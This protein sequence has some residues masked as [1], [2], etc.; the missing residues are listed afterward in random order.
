MGH[1]VQPGRD[2]QM[3]T[4]NKIRHL[5]VGK[6][7]SWRALLLHWKYLPF[8][9]SMVPSQH[10]TILTQR[11]L[12][13]RAMDEMRH[14]YEAA[15]TPLGAEI[16]WFSSYRDLIAYPE[17]SERM[18][19]I[20]DLD[21]LDSPVDQA[22]EQIRTSFAGSDLIAL[23][24]LDSAQLALQCIRSGFTDF[25]LKPTSPE[26]LAWSARRCLQRHEFFDRIDPSTDILR[27]VTQ[28]SS[29][30]S[31]NLVRL[32]T[33]EHLVLLAQCKGAAWLRLERRGE[34]PPRALAIFPKQLSE[35][36]VL[37][38]LPAGALTTTPKTRVYRSGRSLIRKVLVP[39]SN[40][41]ESLLFLWGVPQR[42]SASTLAQAELLVEYAETNIANLQKFQE[43]RHQT[44]IDDLT[45]L[46]NSR[47]L[48]FALS[49][50]MLKCKGPNDH[51]SVLF[52]D[53]DHF[54]AV[55]DRFNH[56]IGS[57][58]LVAIG[59]TIKNTVRQID[60]VFRYGGDEFVVILH[61]TSLEGALEIGERI[62]KSVER[63]IF[64]IQK[65]RL[66]T[67]VSVGIA[68]YPDHATERE[69][70]LRL[71]DEAMYQAKRETRNCVHLAVP[72]PPVRRAS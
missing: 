49:N 3:V 33:V 45:G 35:K 53:V 4:R 25:L 36:Q 23:S 70:L 8:F 10:D 64:V 11:I 40:Y 62:R 46:Y 17:A 6:V 48:K 29:C 43:I 34:A 51:F 2:Y 65:K 19:V 27:A 32:T 47:Y 28:I 59:K 63:R 15:L 61:G 50:A 24:G 16:E 56:M 1:S 69:T 20:V 30:T 42:L 14:P 9:Y 71:A 38:R 67:T 22:L 72:A 13:L 5:T 41:Q 21:C 12:V 31:A 57:S 68:T 60:P 55:N 18:V 26:E 66:Q 52:I 39:G 7:F 37:T 58:F 44:F 54:K